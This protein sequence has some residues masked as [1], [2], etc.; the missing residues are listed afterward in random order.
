MSTCNA[1]CEAEVSDDDEDFMVAYMALE[2]MGSRNGARKKV[3]DPNIP[4]MTGIQWVELTLNDR[5]ECYNMFRMTRSVFYR[6][7][8]TLVQNYGLTPSR[9]ICTKEA[10]A[11]CFVGMWST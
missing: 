11:M 10:L 1:S 8:D 9:G 3:V 4:R 6:L 5:V 2:L 7:H